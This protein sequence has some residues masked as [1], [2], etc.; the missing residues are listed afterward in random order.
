MFSK[1]LLVI[2][3]SSSVAIAHPPKHPNTHRHH[4]PMNSHLQ[5]SRQPSVSVIWSLNG[6][7]WVRVEVRRV[8]V[9]GRYMHGRWISGHWR[10]T[11]R[12]LP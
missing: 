5:A 6:G 9:R 7:H 4:A 2:L 11:R 12:T 3:A 10:V 8:W 1:L